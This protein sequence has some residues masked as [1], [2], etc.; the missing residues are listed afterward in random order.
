MS[1]PWNKVP[2]RGPC[3]VC[4]EYLDRSDWCFGCKQFICVEHFP[5]NPQYGKHDADSHMPP[6]ATIYTIT[7]ESPKGVSIK[8][9]IN[10]G[11]LKDDDAT[12]TMLG[13]CL[14]MAI[15]TVKN[16]EAHLVSG[17]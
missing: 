17:R 2:K 9:A 10:E 16:Q 8:M 5:P 6:L 15:K 11:L 1:K 13:K 4:G 12:T 7:V 14:V 3:S